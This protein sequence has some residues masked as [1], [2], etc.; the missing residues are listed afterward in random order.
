MTLEDLKNHETTFED[1]ISVAYKGVRLWEIVP[2]GQG[3]VALL[4]LNILQSF[5]LQS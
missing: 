5:D 3:I 1:P 4:T 2:N